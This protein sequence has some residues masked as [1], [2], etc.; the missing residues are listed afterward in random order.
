MGIKR[1]R[2]FISEGA[3]RAAHEVNQ[4]YCDA[5][6]DPRSP[7]WEGLTEAQR[8]GV[9]AGALAAIRGISPKKSHALW[10]KSRKDEGWVYGKKKDFDKK[11]SPCMV[12]YDDLPEWQKN[13]D[14]LF[15]AVCRAFAKAT[16]SK[17]I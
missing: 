8:A 1:L 10:L 17:D 4:I 2:E 12:A 6:G 16:C 15:G 13:K 9:I 7:T 14:A 11:T 3:A 5:M